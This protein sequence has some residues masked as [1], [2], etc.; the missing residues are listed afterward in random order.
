[1]PIFSGMS[2]LPSVLG[3]HACFVYSAESPIFVTVKHITMPNPKHPGILVV[4]LG[5]LSFFLVPLFARNLVPQPTRGQDMAVM[6]TV[7]D[8]CLALYRHLGLEGKVSE[9]A[10]RQGLTGFYKIL[11]RQKPILTLIDFTKPS[12]EERMFVID[13]AAQ[14]VLFHSVVAHGKGSGDLYAR[15]F[16]NRNGSHQSSLGFYLTE[17]TYQGSNGYSL[18]LNGLE[19]GINCHAKERAIVVHGASYA[20]PRGLSPTGRLGR[21]WGCPA[22]PPYLTRP[23][24]DAIKEGSVLFIYSD[25]ASY[26][27]NSPLLRA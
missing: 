18:R 9:T 10:F 20:D 21:S 13:V 8:S 26:Q 14:Q 27:R 12:N 25:Q 17:N 6:D 23:I 2:S 15:R 1:M 24:I 11:D 19:P 4:I 16:S 7:K 3:G 22:I 5:L